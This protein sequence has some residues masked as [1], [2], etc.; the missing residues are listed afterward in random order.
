MSGGEARP[1]FLRDASNEASDAIRLQRTNWAND[2][3]SAA[4]FETEVKEGKSLF[5][6]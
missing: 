1:A 6:P 3:M 4:G 5:S 2:L